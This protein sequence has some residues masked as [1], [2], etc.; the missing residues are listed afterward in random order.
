MSLQLFKADVLFYQ[1]FLKANGFYHGNLDGQ[2]ASQT[3]AADAAFTAMS[4]SIAQTH[5]TFHS[6][7]ETNISTLTPKAQVLARQFLKILTSG[8]LDVRIISGTRTYAEQ[9]ALYKIGRF[10]NPG[11]IVTK[12]KGGQSNHNFGIAWDIGI[13][14]HGNYIQTDHDYMLIAPKVL[15]QF[16]NLEWGG[17]WI[18]LKDYPHYQLKSVSN[19]VT[20]IRGLFESGTVY[21]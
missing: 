15:P 5:G 9:D 21:T 2:W 20:Q 1:R 14:N 10:G 12:A 3:D 18:S 7:S 8:G 16:A 13:F 6:R 11:P 4:Q 19:D 17:N